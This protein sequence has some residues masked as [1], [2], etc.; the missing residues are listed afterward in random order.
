MPSTPVSQ[1]ASRWACCIPTWSTSPA[2]RRSS[3]AWPTPARS[4]P[5]TASAPGR[6]PPRRSSSRASSTGGCRR[7]SCAR[8]CRRHRRPGSRRFRDYGTMSFGDV[9]GAAIRYAR[10]GFPTFALLAEVIAANKDKYGAHAATAQIYLPD[11]RPP[12]V[13]E[14]FRQ[15]D[16][17]GSLQYMVDQEA[18]GKGDQ[19]GTRCRRPMTPS[20]AAISPRRSATITWR[21]RRLHDPR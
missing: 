4:S 1:P 17:A 2:W 3:C 15:T 11:G 19:E 8:S 12:E 13:G 10:D 6:K 14:I 21:Q 5:S 16:L 20:I 7:A 9:A 18:A